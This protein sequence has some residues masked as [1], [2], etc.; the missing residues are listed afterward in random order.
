MSKKYNVQLIPATLD[1]FP[2]L[3]NMARFY[4][5][6]MSRY[7]GRDSKDWALP[8]DGLYESFP[9]LN[10]IQDDDRRAFLVRVNG[11]LA[12]FVLLNKITI[13][14]ETTWNMGEFFIMARFQGQGIAKEVLQKVWQEHQGDWEVSVIPENNLALSF[15]HKVIEDETRGCFTKETCLVDFDP[16]QPERIVFRFRVPSLI[17]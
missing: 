14:P 8:K 2:T 16:H 7:C 4:V 6:D 3:H 12:G 10:Y 5:Y 9:F 17:L 11:E 1:D 15:W 13:F